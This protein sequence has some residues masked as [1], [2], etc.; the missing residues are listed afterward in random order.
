M[1]CDWSNPGADPYTGGVAAAVA[2]YGFPDAAQQ[3]IV[4]KWR[5]IEMDGVVVITKDGAQPLSRRFVASDLRDMHYGRDKLCVGEVKRDGW[6]DGHVE[7]ASV[8]CAGQHCIA[9]PTVCRNVS[10][11]AWAPAPLPEAPFRVWDGEPPKAMPFPTPDGPT[12]P[13]PAPSTLALVLIAAL[14]LRKASR[15]PQDGHRGHVCA[16][17]LGS[18]VPSSPRSQKENLTMK[19]SAHNCFSTFPRASRDNPL[20]SPGSVSGPHTTA[21]RSMLRRAAEAAY[22]AVALVCLVSMFAAP[23]L[24]S[25]WAP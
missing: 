2:R 4:R 25:G 10:R 21:T 22:W 19:K 13:I 5:R 8:Y 20:R 18:A 24:W 9:I 6:P 1:A 16:G 14:A 7:L 12:R 11:I 23:E 15:R 3:E 17:L